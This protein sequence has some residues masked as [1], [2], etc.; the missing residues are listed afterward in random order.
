[1]VNFL[2][3]KVVGDFICAIAEDIDYGEKKYNIKVHKVKEE[4]EIEPSGYSTNVIKALW[5]LTGDLEMKGRLPKNM[6]VA[7]Y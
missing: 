5:T 6:T 3:I 1:M 2:D 7:W 4:Y